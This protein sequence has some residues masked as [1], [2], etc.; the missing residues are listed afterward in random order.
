MRMLAEGKILYR[1]H[2]GPYTGAYHFYGIKKGINEASLNKLRTEGYIKI[3]DKITMHGLM[4]YVHLPNTNPWTNDPSW[5][6]YM[7]R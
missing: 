7:R 1:S 4:A 2:M 5:V 6:S 3:T